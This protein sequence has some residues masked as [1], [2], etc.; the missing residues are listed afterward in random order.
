MKITMIGTG[1]VGLVS[2]ACFSQFG[3]DVTCVDLDEEKIS[4]LKKG[5]IPIYEPGLDDMVKENA[6]AGR[7][8][9]TTSLEEGVKGADAVFIAVGTPTRHG[10]GHA[11]LSYVYAAARDIAMAIDGYTVI[12]DKSTVPVGTAREVARIVKETNPDADF[13]VVSNPEFLREGAAIKDFTKPDRVVLGVESDRAKEVMANIY[14]PLSSNNVE[15]MMTGLETAELIKYAANAFLAV[16]ISFINEL[17]DLCEKVGADVESVAQGM[18]SD[19]RIGPRFLQAGPGYGGS[20]FPK[21]TLALVRTAEE[22]G[23]PV[24]IVET[25]VDVNAS[26]KK[27]MAT[28][29]IEACGG[30]VTGKKI[31]ILGV[32][33][34]AETDDM[35]D[36]PSLDI[37]PAL[38]NMG[39]YIHAYDPKGMEEAQEY[40][41]DVNWES[42]TYAAIKDADCAVIITEWN[43]FRM[44]DLS[45]MKDEMAKPILVDL[46]NMYN[47]ERMKQLGI[48]YTSIGRK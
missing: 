40:L 36:S 26:R 5:I 10:D 46:R 16:K 13:D 33:F 14:Q 23:T 9:F 34:K 7:L 27:A 25:V 2:G 43:E 12:V 32:T 18:G 20:C 28:K 42:S 1:Y 45:R 30:D 31:A 17:A 41:S 15:V 3:I 39:A 29:V 35:R 21:D 8:H 44:I 11:D 6:D 4:K 47:P 38:Q 19:S 22:A 24:R 37:I 48:A